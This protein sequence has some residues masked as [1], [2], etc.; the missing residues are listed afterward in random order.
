M[1]APGAVVLDGAVVVAAV[2]LPPSAPSIT[3]VE[4]VEWVRAG[5]SA[6]CPAAGPPVTLAA[7]PAEARGAAAVARGRELVPAPSTIATVGSSS[8]LRSHGLDPAAAWAVCR[9]PTY[10]RTLGAMAA[11]SPKAVEVM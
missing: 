2:S 9:S 4:T 8:T 10:C 11:V 1:S 7:G 5:V 6:A 3:M